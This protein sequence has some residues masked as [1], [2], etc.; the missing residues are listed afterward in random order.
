MM[1]VRKSLFFVPAS[2]GGAFLSAAF[3]FG[4]LGGFAF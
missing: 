1:R 2:L 3:G 4:S